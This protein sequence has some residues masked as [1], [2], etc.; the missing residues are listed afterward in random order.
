MNNENATT[1]IIFSSWNTEI[2]YRYNYG[3]DAKTIEEE[4]RFLILTSKKHGVDYLRI[5]NF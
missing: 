1:E 2:T 5:K 4:I 3:M